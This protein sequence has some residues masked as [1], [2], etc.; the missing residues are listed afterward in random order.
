MKL[1]PQ[2]FAWN[3]LHVLLA[4]SAALGIAT[5]IIF[6][7]KNAQQKKTMSTS[8]PNLWNNRT[9]MHGQA[10]HTRY[11]FQSKDECRSKGYGINQL[12]ECGLNYDLLSFIQNISPILIS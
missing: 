9:I 1:L 11:V 12:I 10:S 2:I 7:R 3:V 4:S 8:Y 6:N 5:L